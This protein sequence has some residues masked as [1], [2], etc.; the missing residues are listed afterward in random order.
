MSTTYYANVADVAIYIRPS[1]I[2]KVVWDEQES[3]GEQD[4]FV[5]GKKFVNGKS[6]ALK[7]HS[8]YEA[9][10]AHLRSFEME[11]VLSKADYE[12][13]LKSGK[14]FYSKWSKD[15]QLHLF[16]TKT[17]FVWRSGRS[18]IFWKFL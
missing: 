11:S 14:P 1:E 16:D 2:P 5:V 18:R 3:F 6:Y 17:H 15:F 13:I 12:L 9:Y 10:C 8:S 7:L 4:C